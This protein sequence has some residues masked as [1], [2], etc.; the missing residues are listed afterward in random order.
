[1]DL[2]TAAA[3]DFTEQV[4]IYPLVPPGDRHVGVRK[5]I[6]NLGFGGF[7][8]GLRLFTTRIMIVEYV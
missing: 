4:L 1:M 5:L 2:N 6:T 7:L 3:P 8:P